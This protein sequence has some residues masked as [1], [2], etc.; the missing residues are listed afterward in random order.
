[1]PPFVHWIH[2]LHCRFSPPPPSLTASSTGLSVIIEPKIKS[3]NLS[4]ITRGHLLPRP[5]PS[6]TSTS[7]LCVCPPPLSIHKCEASHSHTASEIDKMNVHSWTLSFINSINYIGNRMV[8]ARTV[9]SISMD[10]NQ[11]SL[12]VFGIAYHV[13]RL[14]TSCPVRHTKCECVA[15]FRTYI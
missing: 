5:P 14:S 4:F 2:L 7:C 9:E 13:H 1:M 3:I 12:A 6:S 10:W 15:A 8:R 11:A